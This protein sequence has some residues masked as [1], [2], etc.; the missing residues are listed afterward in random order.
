MSTMLTL[1]AEFLDRMTNPSYGPAIN[2]DYSLRFAVLMSAENSDKSLDEEI[3]LLEN[4]NTLGP[5]VWLWIINRARSRDIILSEDLLLHL[6]GRWPDVFIQAPVIDL[7]TRNAEWSSP[8]NVVSIKSFGHPWLSRLLQQCTGYRNDVADRSMFTLSRRA[9]LSLISL[10]QV[11]K[12]ITLD[13]ASTL[14]NHSWEGRSHLVEFFWYR[15]DQLDEET[16][17]IWQSRLHPPNR[18]AGNRR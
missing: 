15:W 3:G 17:V 4:V 8:E 12:G 14:L 5:Y 1:A 6:T 10:L 18:D 2:E 16:Q 13:A 7:A 11:G 9:E